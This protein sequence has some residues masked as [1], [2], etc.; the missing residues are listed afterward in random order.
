MAQLQSKLNPRSE[1]FRAHAAAM[2]ALVDD[3]NARLAKIAKA[4]APTPAPSTWPAASCCRVSGSSACSTP[5][6]RSSRLRR[7]PRWACT[8]RPIAAVPR[9]TPRPA[10][11]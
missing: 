8:P 11:A 1:A 6:R 3:L 5:T 10:P 2:Q 9:W 4:A 7:W